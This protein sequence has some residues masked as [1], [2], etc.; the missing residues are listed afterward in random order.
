M[1]LPCSS[2]IDKGPS[3]LSV[4]VIHRARVCPTLLCPYICT[5]DDRDLVT[6]TCVFPDVSLSVLETEFEC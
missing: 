6:Q 4:A 3:S 5:F 1:G 2:P